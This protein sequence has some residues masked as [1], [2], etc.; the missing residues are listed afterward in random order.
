[1]SILSKNNKYIWKGKPTDHDKL[2]YNMMSGHG[3]DV[4]VLK[5]HSQKCHD[6]RTIHMENSVGCPACGEVLHEKL[7]SCRCGVIINRCGHGVINAV[8]IPYGVVYEDDII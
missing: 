2:L 8:V 3:G 4:T 5:C 7:T 6:C 1:M